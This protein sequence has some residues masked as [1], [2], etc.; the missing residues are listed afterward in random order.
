ML[1]HEART[2]R[3]IIECPNDNDH[4]IF[5]W[6]RAGEP[7]EARYIVAQTPPQVALRCVTISVAFAVFMRR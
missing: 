3:V 6:P 2:L 1:L 4:L 5:Y 7:F